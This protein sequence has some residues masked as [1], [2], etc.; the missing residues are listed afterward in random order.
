M[1]ERLTLSPMAL[2]LGLLPDEVIATAITDREQW[3]ALRQKDVTASV[4][5][6]LV[7]VHEYQTPY[8]LYMEKAGL[9]P[10]MADDVP[11]IT[12]DSIPLPP[13][14]RGTLF[15]PAALQMLRQL[16]PRWKIM[17]A[18]AYF[19]LPGA[20]IG[21]TP[22]AYAVDRDGVRIGRGIIQVKTTSDIVFAK[23][24]RDE[25]GA[26][27]VPLWI[28]CQ[29]ITEAKV[30]GSS[31][32]CVIL[33]VSGITT[34]LHL[35]DIP[36]VE[37]LWERLT[38]EVG[39]FWKRIAEGRPY[40]P[41]YARDGAILSRVYGVMPGQ[42][43]DLTT[44]NRIGSLCQ[45]RLEWQRRKGNAERALE[46]VDNEIVDVLKGAETAEHP[47]YKITRKITKRKEVIVAASQ[48]PVLRITRRG[49][50]ETITEGSAA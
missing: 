37:G 4:I 3:L 38:G 13:M 17:E 32:A 1:T 28:A 27:Q 18:N 46:T 47:A 42:S 34:R 10:P 26:L 45:E 23:K 39:E 50:A 14:L 21:A 25:D 40:D 33:M 20:R 2:A 7:G 30:T 5:G 19:R 9:M 11:V 16:R 41:D 15:E 6:A 31:W 12:E 35:I 44:H 43:V 36:M 24:W 48:Y 49:E 29:A 22:D 8:G